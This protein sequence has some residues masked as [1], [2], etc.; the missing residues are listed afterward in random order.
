MMAT[1]DCIAVTFQGVHNDTFYMS[2]AE[3][4]VDGDS[5]TISSR[6][7]TYNLQCED[8]KFLYLNHEG[9]LELQHLTSNEQSQ[10]DCKFNIHLFNDNS[11]QER[12]GRAV[13]VYANK[14]GKKMVACCRSNNEVYAEAMDLPKKIEERQHK[15]L[16]YMTMVVSNKY[17]F[18]STLY[19]SKFLGFE[20]D[21]R[22]SSLKAVVLL[23]KG[24]RGV[25]EKAEVT[26]TKKV[27]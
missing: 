12:K 21:K 20:P 14:D 18:E 23:E 19:P 9:R 3:S 13:M 1:S 8:K 7:F 27:I 11:L 4:E 2:V 26:L 10:L 5:F 16:F 25:D 15:A 22:N 24:H 6:W 17:M